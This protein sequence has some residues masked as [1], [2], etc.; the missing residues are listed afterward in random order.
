MA[1]FYGPV[2]YADT[3]ETQPGVYEEQ[4]TERM[5]YGELIRNTR[6]LQS[7]ETLNDNVNVANEISIVADPF[8]CLN[9]YRMRYVGFAGAKWKVTNVEVQY[10]RL[11]LTIGGVYNGAENGASDDLGTASR[12]SECLLSTPDRL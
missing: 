6:R 8:A 11:I 9:F 4:I 12:L 2:G 1:K 7:A 3:V 5:Y 10:P